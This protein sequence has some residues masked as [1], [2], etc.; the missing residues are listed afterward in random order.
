[1]AV[2]DRMMSGEQLRDHEETLQVSLGAVCRAKCRSTRHIRCAARGYSADSEEL[3]LIR[4]AARP[5]ASTMRPPRSGGR[6]AHTSTRVPVVERA[7]RPP[8]LH[9]SKGHRTDSSSH[10]MWRGAKCAAASLLH[11]LQHAQPGDGL[12]RGLSGA[13]SVLVDAGF[14]YK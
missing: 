3:N 7:A 1:M 13:V 6:K 5:F 12:A 4:Y 8:D 14:V 9:E 11:D 10:N 2:S